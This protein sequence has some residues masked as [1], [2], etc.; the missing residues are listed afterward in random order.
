[1][2]AFVAHYIETR[3]ASFRRF[4]EAALEP[5]STVIADIDRHIPSGTAQ[6]YISKIR[7]LREFVTRQGLNRASPDELP[8]SLSQVGVTK[9]NDISRRNLLG[10]QQTP[11]SP[12]G[13][14][15]DILQA[16]ERL[17]PDQ[18]QRIRD[19]TDMLLAR[20]AGGYRRMAAR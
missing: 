3:K 2:H 1:M 7:V 12:D 17:D 19:A 15:S 11:R 6:N 10:H 20:H 5:E 4:L 8:K 13:A 14:V 18:L 9:I 16:L